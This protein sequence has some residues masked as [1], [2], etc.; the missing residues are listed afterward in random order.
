VTD[1]PGPA[2]HDPVMLARVRELLAPAL[3]GEGA[4]LIDAT[5]GLAG[6]SFDLLAHCPRAQLVGIDRDPQALALA[7]ERLAPYADRIHL[8]HTTF[9]QL[10][11]VLADLG[12]VSVAAALFDLGVSSLQLDDDDRGFAYRR[13]VALD[14]RMDPTA[15]L[16]AATVLATYP[17]AKLAEILRRYGEERFAARIARR[18]VVAR[19]EGRMRTTADLV[20][21]VEEGVPAA[22]R[23]TG[24]HPAKRTFQAVRIEVNGELD[25][26]TVALPAAL[27]A[28]AVRGRALVLAYH[29]L[30]DRL[31]K[32]LFARRSTTDVPAGVP[33]VPD[34]HQP[35]FRLL[36]RG[37]EWPTDQES[38]TNPRARSARLRAVERIREAA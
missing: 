25:A 7:T 21:A 18:I 12:I 30:E 26:L 22:A 27:D 38:S 17:E 8:A 28:L 9:D 34:A 1:L 16:S 23:R 31:A 20:R 4:V 35:R 15:D 3:E 2:R 13:D 29:S 11:Q 32:Q 33:T 36:T 37:A 24:G 14:M 6:H 5:L 19:A 10:P